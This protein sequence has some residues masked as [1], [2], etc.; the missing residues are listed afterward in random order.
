MKRWHYKKKCYVDV[1]PAI[2]REGLK[3]MGRNHIHF[4]P[5]EVGS[6]TVI[7]GMR[8]DCTVAIYLDVPKALDMGI[9]LFRSANDVVL[10]R[11]DE[12]G[13]VPTELFTRVVEIKTGRLLWC[14][15][16]TM[17]RSGGSGSGAEASKDSGRMGLRGLISLVC[18]CI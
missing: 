8:Q 18:T 7:S 6:R 4:V 17:W 9:K 3:P 10:T 12:A 2:K 14:R 16:G 1:W 11:G 15:S 5:H 13:H